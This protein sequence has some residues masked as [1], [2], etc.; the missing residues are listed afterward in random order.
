MRTRQRVLIALLLPAMTVLLAGCPE[1][2]F[3]GEWTRTVDQADGTKTTITLSFTL[4]WYSVTMT[5]QGVT[6]EGASGVKLDN[7]QV[8]RGSFDV[9]ATKDPQWLDLKFDGLTASHKV[10]AGTLTDAEERRL[11]DMEQSLE[12]DFGDQYQG[13][14]YQSVCKREGDILLFV[15]NYGDLGAAPANWF[16]SRP[17]NLDRADEFTKK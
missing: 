12:E 1:L 7:T 11:S 8:I 10:V 4:D 14:T 16:E 17:E 13:K 6:L 15:W 2:D 5:Q 3:G 9:D